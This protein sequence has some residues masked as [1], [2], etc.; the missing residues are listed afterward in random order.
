MTL[1]SLGEFNA[2][3]WERHEQSNAPTPNGIACPDCG[4]E[5]WDT[6]PMTTLTSYPPQKTVGCLKISGGCG[7]RGTRIS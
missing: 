2:E 5:L 6:E 7:F 1:R 3:A 4:L